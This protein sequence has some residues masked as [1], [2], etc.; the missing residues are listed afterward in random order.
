MRSLSGK[1]GYFLLE[2]LNSFATAYYFN[3]LLF[4]LRDTYGFSNLHNLL[5][6]ALHGLIYI[7]AS[8]YAGR[9]GQRRGNF[10]SLRIGF[11]G[12]VLGILVGWCLPVLWGQ[13]LA[14]MIWTVTL[15]FTWPMLEALVSENEPPDRLPHRV[16]LYNVVWAATAALGYS[17]GGWIFKHLG[18]SSLYWLPIFI[19]GVQW[20]LTWPLARLHATFRAES[21]TG[22]ERLQDSPASDSLR[23]HFQRLAWLANPFN[24]MAINTIVAMAPGLAQKVGLGLTEAG[25]VFSLWFYIRAFAFLKLWL[26]PGWHYRFGWFLTGLVGLLVS[27]LVLL[28][29]TSIPLLLLSQIGFGWCSALLYYSSLYYAMDGSQSHSEH[30]G[31]HEALIG[32]GICGG[33]ALSSAAQWLTGSPMAPAW[34]VAGVLAAAVG[35]VCHLHHRAKSGS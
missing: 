2:G 20:C 7:P 18:G 16:G 1:A 19:H 13:L 10:L 9:F 35:W 12:M 8:L 4:L 5:I 14:L 30:G 26:W 11:A 3:Y 23:P 25:L 27:Y 15:C 6:G 33:P 32:V 29:A 21:S 31:I 34:A 28:T 22:G 17:S 24:Y